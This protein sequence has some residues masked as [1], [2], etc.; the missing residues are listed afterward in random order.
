M[1]GIQYVDWESFIKA[2]LSTIPKVA[3]VF[4]FGVPD[5]LYSEEIMAW[6]QL[7]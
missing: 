5:D 3:Q 1:Q 7:R 6:I 2:Y 4:V